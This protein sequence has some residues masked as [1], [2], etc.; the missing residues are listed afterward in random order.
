MTKQD[1]PNG[2][3]HLIESFPIH[4]NFNS[5][6]G[7]NDIAVITIKTEITFN[8]VTQPIQLPKHRV[9]DKERL[10]AAGWGHT[11]YP[12]GASANDLQWMQM[13]VVSPEECHELTGYPVGGQICTLESKG[14][15]M[16]RADSGSPLIHTIDGVDE[17][18]GLGSSVFLCAQGKPDFFTDVYFFKYWILNHSD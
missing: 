17:V 16:C 18:V 7:M 2:Q 3:R 4:E 14:H 6:T 8:D 10:S 15:G 5:A 13:N 1:D 12:D 11:S 9:V